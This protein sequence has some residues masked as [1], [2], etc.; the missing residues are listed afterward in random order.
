MACEVLP[1]GSLGRCVHCEVDLQPAQLCWNSQVSHLHRWHIF[2][3]FGHS[4]T[5]DNQPIPTGQPAVCSLPEQSMHLHKHFSTGAVSSAL[6]SVRS[7]GQPLHPEPH[8]HDAPPHTLSHTGLFF[9][10]D[11]SMRRMK[12]HAHNPSFSSKP[13][14]QG[15]AVLCCAVLCCRTYPGGSSRAPRAQ[16]AARCP[17]LSCSR[18]A[19]AAPCCPLAAAARPA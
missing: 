9:L 5:N 14:P 2:Q 18:T 16:H 4:P 15:H 1:A 3:V 8:M 10:N 19:A 13:Q 7:R 11:H 12:P 17:P 6:S